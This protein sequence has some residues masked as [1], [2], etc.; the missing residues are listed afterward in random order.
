L[1]PSGGSQLS[2]NT[3][4][5]RLPWLCTF[6]LFHLLSSDRRVTW[7]NVNISRL[8]DVTKSETPV[9]KGT[10]AIQQIIEEIAP[11]SA[12]ARQN[13]ALAQVVQ[14]SE[15]ELVSFADASKVAKGE[16]RALGSFD[17]AAADDGWFGGK[18]SCGGTPGNLNLA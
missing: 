16:G 2:L 12:W 11:G 18:V 9:A 1:C 3:R 13:A 8:V 5:D 6:L 17:D 4:L 15:R 7:R 14:E 10:E